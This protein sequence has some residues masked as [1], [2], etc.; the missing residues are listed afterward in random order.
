MGEPFLISK[1]F[2]F[3]GNTIGKI[4]SLVFKIM[5]IVGAPALVLWG[6]YVVFVRPHIVKPP[7]TNNTTITNPGVVNQDCSEQVFEAICKLQE[8]NKKKTSWLELRIWKAFKLEAG[9]VQ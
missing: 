8:A 7:P 6:A 5:V 9:D 4:L 1:L 3:S 2:D